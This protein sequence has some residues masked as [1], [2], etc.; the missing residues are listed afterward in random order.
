MTSAAQEGTPANYL[1]RGNYRAIETCASYDEICELLGVASVASVVAIDGP[2]NGGKTSLAESV[3]K[4][5]RTAGR[6]TCSIPLDYFMIAR[7]ART[8]IYETIATG[9]LEISEYSAVGWRQDEYRETLL[10][11]KGIIEHPLRSGAV[12][13][14]NAYDRDT[15]MTDETQTISVISGGVIVTEGVGLHAYH[16]D[17]FDLGIRVDA[18]NDIL[19]ERVIDREQQKPPRL[20]LPEDF[21]T[22]RYKAVDG[23]HT[24]HLRAISPLVDLVIDTSNFSEMIVYE[25][26]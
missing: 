2:A 14:P 9:D 17:L 4:F 11:A 8:R 25:Q 20:R 24:N 10:C 3:K 22:W 7:Q 5:Y 21:L 16:S 18:G 12:Q 6:A 13:I 23:P 15:G 1:Q 26:L 19:L